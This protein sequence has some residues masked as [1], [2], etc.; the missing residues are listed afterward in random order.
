MQHLTRIASLA[1]NQ[2]PAHLFSNLITQWTISVM[3]FS[4]DFVMSQNKMARDFG[5]GNHWQRWGFTM[6][7]VV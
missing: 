1:E 4:D 5:T 3:A 6:I 7:S 2:Y